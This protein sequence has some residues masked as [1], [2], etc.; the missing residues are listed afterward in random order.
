MSCR[1]V[2]SRKPRRFFLNRLLAL[3][4]PKWLITLTELIQVLCFPI[5]VWLVIR[6]LNRILLTKS[7]ELSAGYGEHGPFYGT[8]PVRERRVFMVLIRDSVRYLFYRPPACQITN[9]SKIID[10]RRREPS[11]SWQTTLVGPGP[12]RRLAA[13]TRG[14]EQFTLEVSTKSYV[15]PRL[16]QA[17]DGLSIVHFADTHFCGA[18]SR[19]YFE[20]VCEQA[21]AAT[22]ADLFVFTGDLLDDPELLSWLPETLGAAEGSALW[23]S[24]SFLAIM[25][26]T[27]TRRRFEKSFKNLAGLIWPVVLWKSPLPSPIARSF[28]PVMKLP[29]WELIPICQPNRMINFGYCSATLPKQHA[30][31]PERTAL[32]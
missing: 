16:P 26:G 8:C 32:I 29:G 2:T 18:V 4:Q 12:M 31:G 24:I 11:A 14:N 6:G 19:T 10:F 1:R 20:K 27:T 7:F 3:K 13:V 17:W 15:L 5:F 30:S 9:D 21:S 25:I 22:P 23:V 28:C